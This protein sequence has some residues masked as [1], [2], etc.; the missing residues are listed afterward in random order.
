MPPETALGQNFMID[1]LWRGSRH[2]YECYKYNVARDLLLENCKIEIQSWIQTALEYG[3]SKK[4]YF[5]DRWFRVTIY[6][7]SG[8]TWRLLA[9]DKWLKVLDSRN[10]ISLNKTRS[11]LFPVKLVFSLV[12]LLVECRA[13]QFPDGRVYV[14]LRT[15]QTYLYAFA[16]CVT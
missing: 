11:L 1:Q 12:V 10:H 9:S 2:Q 13:N 16:N 3:L 6:K 14:L 7:E 8:Y 5:T 15:R 4:S